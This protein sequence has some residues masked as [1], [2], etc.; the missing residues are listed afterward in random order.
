M[1]AVGREVERRRIRGPQL[2]L[3]S[4]VVWVVE[5]LLLDVAR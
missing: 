3:V 5:L 4:G 2:E 1:L